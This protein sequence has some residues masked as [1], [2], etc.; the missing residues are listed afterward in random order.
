VGLQAYRLVQQAGTVAPG[1]KCSTG[2][3][4]YE[5]TNTTFTATG[6]AAGASYAFR[7]CAMDKLGNTAAGSTATAK[8]LP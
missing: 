4:L 7:V 6:L 1:S 8:A 5:G 3:V 2:T